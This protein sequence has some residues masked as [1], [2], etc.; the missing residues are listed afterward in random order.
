VVTGALPGRFFGT[1]AVQAVFARKPGAFGHVG[2]PAA[3][4]GNPDEDPVNQRV[5]CRW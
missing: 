1:I 3:G 2:K 5:C 4:S